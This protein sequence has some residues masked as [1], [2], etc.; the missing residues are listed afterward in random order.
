MAKPKQDQRRQQRIEQE[1]VVDAYD[2][3]ERAMGWYAYL[4]DQLHFPFPAR[5]SSLRPISPLRK[6][7]EVEVAGLAAADECK[8]EMFV[9]VTW[10]DR[11]L[12][13][14]LAQLEALR[15]DKTTRQAVEDWHYWVD[16]GCEF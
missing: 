15:A 6:G 10:E 16:Q 3:Q 7:Q 1:I 13:V 11:T 9:T 2:A 8:H 14:P 12:A 5:C 4:E